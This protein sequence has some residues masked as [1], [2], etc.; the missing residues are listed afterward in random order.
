[1][2]AIGHV[3]LVTVVGLGCAV[4]HKILA[5]LRGIGGFEFE[6]LLKMACS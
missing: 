2:R 4:L 1:M 6:D 3:V 5:P